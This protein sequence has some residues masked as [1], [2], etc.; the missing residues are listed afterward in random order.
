MLRRGSFWWN[1]EDEL[2][3][4]LVEA[5]YVAYEERGYSVVELARIMGARH[6]RNLYGLMRSEGILR[7]I[8]RKRRKNIEVHQAL[9]TALD[10]CKLS[11]LQWTNSHDIDAEKTAEALK[12]PEKPSDMTSVLAHSA[13]RQDFRFLYPKVYCLP[14]PMGKDI[15]IPYIRSDIG[16][17]SQIIS[18]DKER[19]CFVGVVVGIEQLKV[20]GKTCDEVFIKMKNRFVIISSINKL[21]LLPLRS[22]IQD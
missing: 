15:T 3:P 8:G 17:F 21:R 14:V 12:Y 19:S 1:K 20:T 6:C 2:Y 7:K 18:W 22:A 4:F 13:F 5:L 10:K 16:N 9:Q 11:F